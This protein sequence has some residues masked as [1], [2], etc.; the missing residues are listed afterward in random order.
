YVEIPEIVRKTILDIG[1][2][3]S[4]NGFDGATCGVNVSI[5]QQST[6]IY[7]GVSTSLETRDG[8][9]DEIDKQGAGD[10]G[11]MFGYASNE[12]P[13]LLRAPLY[14]GHRLSERWTK[15]RQQPIS[16]MP[17]LLPDGK[18]QVTI[19][20]DEHHVPQSVETLV[21]STQHGPDVTQEQL[22]EDLRA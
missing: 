8:S 9:V 11:L 2:D 3:S 15:A 18:T 12:T 10:Q 6:D 7:D 5:G 19:G 21:V 17:Y 4:A 20:Y 14:L 22:H 16:P 13:A 1:Y